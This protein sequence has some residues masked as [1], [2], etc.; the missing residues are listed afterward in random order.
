MATGKRRSIHTTSSNFGATL[1]FRPAGMVQ[2]DR[3]GTKPTGEPHS[4]QFIL[5]SGLLHVCKKILLFDTLTKIGIY[6]AFVFF[7]SVIAD[8]LTV[9]K[10]YFSNS[11]NFF[12]MYFIKWGWAWLLLIAGSWIS[13]ASYVTCCGKRPLIAKH[14]YRLIIATLIWKVWMWV[15][16]YIEEVSGRCISDPPI[17]VNKSNCLKAGYFWSGLDISGHTFIIIY[18]T[19]ILAE[20]GAAF[21][22]WE[23]LRETIIKEKHS[24]SSGVENSNSCLKNLSNEDVDFLKEAHD[25]LSVYVRGLFF[26][27]TLQL[28]FWDVALVSTILY[29]HTIVE[30]LAGMA[31]AF[32]SWFVT[33]RGLFK[34]QAVGFVSPGDGLFKYTEQKK[35]NGSV[36]AK[37]FRTASTRVQG[38]MFMG[39]PLRFENTRTN[40]DR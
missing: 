29:Y 18:T 34:I 25:K 16:T 9:P 2:E 37:G 13:L 32:V 26:V 40:G 24:R 7:G 15:F 8:L 30:K 3:G 5:L 11:D 22:G 12:N 21:I 14:L 27:M 39:R 6:F 35:E 31:V 33:Y 36:K 4:I 38:P 10:S 28:I 20:E 17:R 23:N 19:L 1:N